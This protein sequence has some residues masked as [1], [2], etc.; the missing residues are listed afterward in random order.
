MPGA[1]IEGRFRVDRYNIGILIAQER[2]CKVDQYST[3]VLK[4]EE[5]VRGIKG[6]REKGG[7]INMNDMKK[8]KKR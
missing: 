1:P 7:R 2:P 6:I 3:I 5:G 4:G 8:I